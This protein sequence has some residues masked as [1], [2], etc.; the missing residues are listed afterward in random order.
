LEGIGSRTETFG[1]WSRIL[2]CKV[3]GADHSSRNLVA[4]FFVLLK[5]VWVRRE[6]RKEIGNMGNR[7][8][9]WICFQKC[10]SCTKK[11]K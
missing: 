2:I 9:K 8:V 3:E 5:R 11:C 1:F 10:V 7:R 6:L 4:S